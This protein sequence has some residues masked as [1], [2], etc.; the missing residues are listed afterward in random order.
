MSEQISSKVKIPKDYIAGLK[1]NYKSE[2]IS[3]FLVFLIALPLCLGISKASGFPSIAGI[4]TAIIG[5]MVVS[6]FAG[7]IPTIKGPAAGLIVIALG[8]VTELGNGDPVAGYKFALAT[9][10][11]SGAIQIVFGLVKA[12]V[13]SSFFPHSVVH[14]ML[15]AIGIIIFSKQI[16]IALGVIPEGKEPLAL[17]EEIPLSIVKMNPEVAIIGAASLA[18][19]FLKPLIRHPVIKLIPGPLFVLV[20]A[21]PMGMF[22][23]FEHPHDF[24]LIGLD[25]HV[26]PLQL[27]VSLPKSILSGITFPDFSMVYSPVSIKYI[28]MFALVGSVESLLS[29]KAIDSIDPYKRKSNMDKD[30]LAVGVGNVMSGFIGGL[31][32]ISEIVRSSANINNGGKTRWSNFFHGFFLLAFVV[33]AAGLIQMIP[34]AALAAMLIFTGYNLASPQEFIKT[35]KIGPEQLLY[36]VTTIII[37]I[38]T[39]LLIG[40]AFGIFVKL[41]TSIMYGVPL[42]SIFRVQPVISDE[43]GHVSIKMK[44]PGMFTNVIPFNNM[45]KKVPKSSKV[46]LD[47]SNSP[48]VDYTFQENL[49]II[50]EEFFKYGGHLD[51]KGFEKHHYFSD[52]P[53]AIRIKVR[54]PNVGLEQEELSPRQSLILLYAEQ[55]KYDF[56]PLRAS[57]IIKFSLSAFNFSRNCMYG[58]NLITG[59]LSG[60][61]FLIADVMLKEQIGFRADNFKTTLMY[62][63][64]IEK[65]NIPNF[66]VEKE[67]IMDKIKELQGI[68][69]IDFDEYPMFSEKYFLVGDDEHEVRTFFKKPIIELFEISENI[70]VEAKHDTLLIHGEPKLMNL[71]DIKNMLIFTRKFVK[72]LDDMLH[73]QQ[74]A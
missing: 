70:Y 5:G 56:D 68:R 47:F 22:F 39:D 61:R 64:D 44:D 57:G 55:N 32:M 30:L 9:I 52:H 42:R 60:A 17:L 20:F 31:P 35:S 43:D 62:M 8:A 25:Y 27:L 18:I 45:L 59:S 6:F 53:M 51:A 11:V 12:G 54:N 46:T 15:A 4:Y 41:F 34:N 19:L 24:Q 74:P 50:E 23:D 69:D 48:L 21:V 1:E 29:A 67:G 3:G 2:L 58:E 72:I 13:L 65:Y 28:I 16:H 66:Y 14:G 71:K 63:T 33:L 38:A 37:T 36:F 7:S 73:T 40:V 26:D 49:H 10:V